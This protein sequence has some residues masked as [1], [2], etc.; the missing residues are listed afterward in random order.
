MK[1]SK[2]D[3]SN[4]GFKITDPNCISIDFNQIY[5]IMKDSDNLMK[6]LRIDSIGYQGRLKRL[7]KTV[8]YSYI[9]FH[10]RTILMKQ[11]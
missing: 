6:P 9:L 4:S 5:E 10:K 1:H 11:K 8:S 7:I 2:T 3:D